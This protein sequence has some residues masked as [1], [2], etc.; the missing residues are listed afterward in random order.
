VKGPRESG[1]A[2]EGQ[3]ARRAKLWI[4]IQRGQVDCFS[5]AGGVQRAPEMAPP[6]CGVRRS[7]WDRDRASGASREPLRA[8][9]HAEVRR[10][11]GNTEGSTETTSGQG[12]RSV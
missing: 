2:G 8:Q 12:C 6:E 5:S 1:A 3:T 9:S 7:T 11:E 10:M 4:W